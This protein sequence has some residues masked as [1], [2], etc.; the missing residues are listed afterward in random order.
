[1]IQW[2]MVE[3]DVE[4]RKEEVLVVAYIDGPFTCFWVKLGG[5]IDVT[6][7]EHYGPYIVG[8]GAKKYEREVREAIRIFH[9]STQMVCTLKVIKGG[10]KHDQNT[11]H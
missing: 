1:M 10:K 9:C 2:R 7:R 8:I 6:V 5:L 3:V 11:H 4:G